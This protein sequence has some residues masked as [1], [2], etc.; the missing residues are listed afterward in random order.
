MLTSPL[1]STALSYVLG[2]SAPSILFLVK[3]PEGSSGQTVVD[4][5][6]A[7]DGDEADDG[8]EA[9]DGDEADDGEETDAAETEEFTETEEMQ[10]EGAEKTASATIGDAEASATDTKD[11]ES[12]VDLTAEVIAE[13][14]TKSRES[15]AEG[16]D[17]AADLVVQSAET[18]DTVCKIGTSVAGVATKA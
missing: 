16:K 14:E 9:E 12:V 4:K 10:D 11:I 7:E 13:A 15:A 2:S 3:A 6:E 17:A 5:E 18:V 1:L 8:E